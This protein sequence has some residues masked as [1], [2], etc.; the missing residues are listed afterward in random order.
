MG[1]KRKFS[2]GN[3]AKSTFESHNVN[4]I[5]SAN[6]HFR[7]IGVVRETK[8]ISEGIQRSHLE[9]KVIKAGFKCK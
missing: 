7:M 6:L 8:H 9:Y 5:V 2:Q 3:W 1:V 4:P